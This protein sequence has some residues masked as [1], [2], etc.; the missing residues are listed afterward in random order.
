MRKTLQ[1]L[2][3]I[4]LFAAAG[5]AQAVPTIRAP[6]GAQFWGKIGPNGERAVCWKGFAANMIGDFGARNWIHPFPGNATWADGCIP[7]L[8]NG[9]FN[10]YLASNPQDSKTRVAM[11]VI[12]G[13]GDGLKL[14]SYVCREGNERGAKL[15]VTANPANDPRCVK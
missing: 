7:L 8:G 13:G 10:F 6:D 1:Y 11:E 3:T 9:S 4:V 5:L 12:A 2:I 15:L 14:G